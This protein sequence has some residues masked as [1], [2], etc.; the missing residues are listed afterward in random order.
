MD[1]FWTSRDAQ[2]GVQSLELIGQR[3]A[4]RGIVGEY[5]DYGWG[6]INIGAAVDY[7]I[8][9]LPVLPP[10]NLT[11][12]SNANNVTLTWLMPQKIYFNHPVLRYRVYRAPV[13]QGFPPDP[14]AEVTNPGS[15]ITY[16]DDGLA[17]GDY[18]YVVT[19]LYRNGESEPT[20]VAQVH[21]A[22][23]TPTG[24]TAAALADTAGHI[25]HSLRK[26]ASLGPITQT[27]RDVLR[28]QPRGILAIVQ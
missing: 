25:G 20:N 17:W 4:D 8:S 5:N 12:M 24:L 21:L 18:Q 1:A 23:S 28:G 14:I 19:A 10:R 13:G 11:A 16:H 3:D 7:A 26:I 2:R 22:L 9:T 27:A 15:I 6:I